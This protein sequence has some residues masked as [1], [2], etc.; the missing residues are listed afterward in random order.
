M[1]ERQSQIPRSVV[2]LPIAAT[3][4]N[5]QVS[6]AEKT[7]IH[8]PFEIQG[9]KPSRSREHCM[10]ERLAMEQIQE[11][12]VESIKQGPQECVPQRTLEQNVRA[13]VP[14]VQEQMIVQDTPGTQ[15]RVPRHKAVGDGKYDRVRVPRPRRRSQSQTL[16][17]PSQLRQNPN[18]PRFYSVVDGTFY[19]IATDGNTSPS[20][21]TPSGLRQ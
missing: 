5:R 6:L 19:G 2:S 13:P 4:A 18:L 20:T 11:Q 7:E 8:V 15:V 1:K 16:Q 3:V 14:T 12:I 10:K 21:P 9:R 17:D